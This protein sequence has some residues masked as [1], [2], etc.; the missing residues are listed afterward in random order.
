MD[1]SG[2]VISQLSVE[3]VKGVKSI[4]FQPSMATKIGGDNHQGKSSLID[5]IIL[6]LKNR[7]MGNAVERVIHDGETSAETEIVLSNGYIVRS[8]WKTLENGS[9]TRELT[10]S[11]KDGNGIKRPQDTL[12]SLINGFGF[13]PVKF[14]GLS[15]EAQF[16]MIISLTE[17]DINK[18]N[19]EKEKIMMAR[20]DIDREITRLENV[21]TEY[22]FTAPV[23]RVS[24]ET[25]S[26]E[27]EKA[28]QSNNELDAA[29]YNIN[30]YNSVI[31]TQEKSIDFLKQK[32]EK[33][34]N[35]IAEFEKEIKTCQTVIEN[36][37]ID[38][39][40]V[41]DSCQT[42][43]RIDTSVLITKLNEIA[44]NNMRAENYEKSLEISDEI[45]KKKVESENLNI[46]L[47]EIRMS[48]IK[49]INNLNLIDGLSVDEEKKVVMI[50]NIPV[51]DLSSSEQIFLATKLAMK[52]SPEVKVILLQN[53]S[54]FDKKTL[55]EITNYCNSEGWQV[56]FETV[57]VGEIIIKEGYILDPVERQKYIAEYLSE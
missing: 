31:A 54:L 44:D 30:A 43:Q 8:K 45:E 48:I 56:I 23:L 34:R 2:I 46:Q 19:A 38:I 33:Y 42:K 39:K 27:L 9:I 26:K 51:K 40:N 4:S 41:K 11:D 13:D 47:S 53:A 50:N 24:A 18:I 15:R 25:V 7:E 36:H 35:E 17:L 10:I 57:G 37:K 3:N 21:L 16:Q 55:R 20:R 5:A 1:N 28:Q 12:D 22:S 49:A 14:Y 32:I 6:T 29:D 52:A